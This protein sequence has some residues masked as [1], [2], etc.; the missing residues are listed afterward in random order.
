M[1]NEISANR[2]AKE[3]L[4]KE[5]GQ[6]FAPAQAA[7]ISHYSG[8]SVEKITALRSELR[9][10][11][12]RLRVIKNTLV[13]RA[14]E[15]TPLEPLKDHFKGPTALAYTDHDPVALAKALTT[16]AKEEEKL[17][18]RFG[19]LGGQLL[20]KQQVEALANTPSREVLLT[21]L[22]SSLQSPYAGLV[23]T[24]SGVLRK[25]VYALDAVRRKKE[26]QG[27]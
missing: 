18:I 14:I 12:V 16:F 3:K 9:K 13:M 6:Q 26:E 27:L 17:V 11:Q 20:T 5:F 15:G 19:V 4:I 22:V 2:R 7:V 23:Y 1:T 24:L 21:R 10:Q 25:F 8:I